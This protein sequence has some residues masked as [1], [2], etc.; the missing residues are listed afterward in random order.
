MYLL[1]YE[2]RRSFRSS[3]RQDPFPQPQNPETCRLGHHRHL[4]ALRNPIPTQRP[5]SEP[6]HVPQDIGRRHRPIKYQTGQYRDQLGELGSEPR[7]AGNG[8]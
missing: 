5:T 2:Q 1:R 3:G 6:Q 8:S 4:H 7:Q